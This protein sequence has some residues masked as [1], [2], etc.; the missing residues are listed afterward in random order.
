MA[1][2]S[3]RRDVF[4]CFWLGYLAV[5]LLHTWQDRNNW[6]FCSYNMFSY[7]LGNRQTQQRV[8]LVTDQGAVLGPAPPWGLMPVE[9]FR[10]ERI[11]D[12]VFVKNPDKKLKDAM[13]GAI[14][15]RL[16]TTQWA[17]W[18]EIRNS[19]TPPSGHQIVA[20]E[21]SYVD[22]DFTLCD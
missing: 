11:L 18:D 7:Q 2:L 14:I 22:V 6:P 20:L 12:Y 13:C 16:N 8:T 1:E 17:G 3:G 19:F 21:F 15:N 4:Q 10:V 9:F 5:Q